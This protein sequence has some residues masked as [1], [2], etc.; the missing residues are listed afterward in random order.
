VN[1]KQYLEQYTEC[2]EI[3]TDGSKSTDDKVGCSFCI[4]TL[5]IAVAHR[6]TDGTSVYASELYAIKSA[7]NWVNQNSEM[8]EIKNKTKIILSDSL[9]AV[10]SLNNKISHSKP[11]LLCEVVNLLKLHKNKIKVIWIPSHVGIAGNEQADLL[12]KSALGHENVDQTVKTELLDKLNT[13]T[14]YVL[15]K[16]QDMWVNSET[17]GNYRKI[18]PNVSTKIKY[19]NKNRLTETKIT[20]LRLG[21][22]CLAKYL[23]DIKSHETGLCSN[24][25]VPETIEHYLM[26]CDKTKI[27]TEL[28]LEC[29]KTQ[30]PFELDKILGKPKLLENLSKLLTSKI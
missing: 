19:K 21:K 26:H 23:K 28:K 1:T 17:G 11:E 12:A 14:D 27:K 6:L 16:W 5:N 9:S 22:C 18:E 7:V 13:A 4:P 20:R 3:Y 25:S 2:V 10:Q 29:C 30:T 24:C 15:S 8:P